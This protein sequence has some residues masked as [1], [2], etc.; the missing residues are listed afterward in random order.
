[1]KYPQVTLYSKENCG[2]CDEV[3]LEL[4]HLHFTYP[5]RLLEVDIEQDPELFARYFLSIPVLKI[6]D[7]QLEAPITAVQL[8]TALQKASTP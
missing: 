3:K 5:H 2:L 8:K 1:M 4:Q 6:G 7:V